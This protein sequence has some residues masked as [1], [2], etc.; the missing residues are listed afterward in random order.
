MHTAKP[1]YLQPVYMINISVPAS[2]S[3]ILF[4]KAPVMFIF[5]Q[6]KLRQMRPLR[7]IAG[8]ALLNA[9]VALL[10]CQPASCDLSAT[11]LSISML[12]LV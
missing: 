8:L 11:D 5:L 1:A 4:A 12:S 2:D 6:H 3:C 7:L 9:S 10:I